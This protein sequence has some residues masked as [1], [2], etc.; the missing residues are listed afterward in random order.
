[1]FASRSIYAQFFTNLLELLVFEIEFAL[2]EY[3]V[4]NIHRFAEEHSLQYQNLHKVLTGKRPIHKG[5][6]LA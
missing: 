5:W 3:F 1:M 2:V 6:T 4:E